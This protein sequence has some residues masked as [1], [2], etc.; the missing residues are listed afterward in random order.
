MNLATLYQAQ[1]RSAEAESLAR[2]ALVISEKAL[3]PDH[4]D[5]AA[6]LITWPCSTRARAVM[7]RL[8]PP[9]PARARNFGGTL[10]S[11]HRTFIA[12]QRVSASALIQLLYFT[13]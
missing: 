2:R 13:T 3:G 4:A 9:S 12:W 8:S 7:P 10:S 6:T 1:G 11:E 5:V